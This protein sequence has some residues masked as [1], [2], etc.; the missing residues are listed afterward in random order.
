MRTRLTL[1]LL[2]SISV[3][4]G[5]LLLTTLNLAGEA[6]INPL[7]PVQTIISGDPCPPK[8]LKKDLDKLEEYFTQKSITPVYHDSGLRYIVTQAGTGPT[9]TESSTVTIN[10]KMSVL[11]GD[12]VDQGKVKAKLKAFIPGWRAGLPLLAAGSRAT[13]FI[14]SCLGYGARGVMDGD[15]YKI[16]PSAV[17]VSTIEVIEVK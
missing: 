11:N 5:L 8:Q 4:L 10:F 6:D 16:P 13:L 2:S 1:H 9:P 15:Y 14:P 3:A 7:T 12:V 17:L